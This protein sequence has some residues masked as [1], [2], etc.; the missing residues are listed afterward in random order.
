MIK[1]RRA[2]SEG[3]GPVQAAVWSCVD[4]SCALI[5]KM[6]FLYGKV[7]PETAALVRL[8]LDDEWRYE[9]VLTVL[10]LG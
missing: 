2:P 3:A 10:Q 8:Y 7:A 4:T 1:V 9:S 5:E 6:Q